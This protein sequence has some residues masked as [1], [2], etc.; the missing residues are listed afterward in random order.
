MPYETVQYP[1]VASYDLEATTETSVHWTKDSHVQIQIQRRADLKGTGPNAPLN[2]WV[3]LPG[4]YTSRQLTP[5]EFTERANCDPI[6]VGSVK[7]A[8]GQIAYKTRG[9]VDLGVCGHAAEWT[10]LRMAGSVEKCTEDLIED[11]PIVHFGDETSPPATIITRPLDRAEINNMIRVLRR[12]RDAA[13]GA[14]A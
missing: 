8:D 7:V 3:E 1:A 12:A 9:R 11:W 14:D 4:P 6:P 2:T 13:Y 5:A 10:V